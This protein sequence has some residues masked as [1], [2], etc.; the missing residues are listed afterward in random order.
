MLSSMK[1]GLDKYWTAVT[2]YNL[3]LKKEKSR[4][5]VSQVR[6]VGDVLSSGIKLDPQKVEA[7]NAKLTPGNCKDL[8]RFLGVETY[9]P[10]CIPNVSQKSA[11]LRLLL[12]K[13]AE[14]SWEKAEDAVFSGLKRAISSAPVLT[15]FNSKDPVTL[16]VDASGCC[17]SLE[18]QP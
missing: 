11:P 18:R 8:Q 6:Y 14:W 12:Q 17:Y 13:D 4:F 3:K 2:G 15:F 16:S 10:K 7:I 9:L 5:P 1:Q